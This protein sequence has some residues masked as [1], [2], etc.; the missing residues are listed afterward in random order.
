VTVAEDP[1]TVPTDEP[2]VSGDAPTGGPGAPATP[3][4]YVW[5]TP[6]EPEK[7]AKTPRWLIALV[8]AWALFLAVSGTIYAL[9]GSPTVREQTTIAS[10]R[11]TIDRA[12]T[13]VIAAAGSGPI[14]IVGPFVQTR[15]CD[16]TPVRSGVE[17]ARTVDLIAAPGTES[18]LLKTIADGLPKAYGAKAGPGDVL[19]LYA[20]AGDYVG[21][22]GN[23][24]APGEVEIR[25]ATGCRSAGGAI[26][27]VPAPSLDAGEMAPIRAVLTGLGASTGATTTSAA[28]VPC[29]DGRGT[30][31]TVSAHLPPG[32]VT[33]PL[34]AALANLAPHPAA[35][36]PTL[37]AYRSGSLDV[38][39]GQDSTGTTISS[40]R[41]CGQ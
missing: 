32:L 28:E 19:E 5:A 23:V 30:L 39:A 25:A 3:P 11:P 29:L 18:G 9:H 40:T 4:E 8:A 10:A 15:T 6:P 1:E 34:N 22:V 31:R 14:V 35:S 7:A 2:P 17:Y 38:V 41:L 26:T 12:I 36:D 33:K 16:I 20:D 24:P 37:V 21:L 27:G 13:N